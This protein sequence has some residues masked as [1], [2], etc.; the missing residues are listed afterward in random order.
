MARFGTN[1]LTLFDPFA[2]VEVYRVGDFD[3][4][5]ITTESGQVIPLPDAG[6]PSEIGADFSIYQAQSEVVGYR[7]T[8]GRFYDLD[9]SPL[10]R[11]DLDARGGQQIAKERTLTEGVFRDR[12]ADVVVLPRAEVALRVGAGTRLSA[13]FNAHARPADPALTSGTL[14]EYTFF[15]A[16]QGDLPNGALRPERVSEVGLS[17]DQALAVGRWAG[18]IGATGYVRRYRDLVRAVA[19]ND[20]FPS[21]YRSVGNA[22]AATVPGLD[23][24]LDGTAGR[25]SVFARGGVAWETFEVAEGGVFGEPTLAD[26]SRLAADAA[27]ALTLDTRATDGPSVG[28][29]H[30]LGGL[31][32][33]AVWRVASGEPYTRTSRAVPVTT[34]DRFL[35]Y[36]GETGAEAS[37]TRT[38]LDLRLARA[39]GLGAAG[40]LEAALWVENLLGTVQVL[41]AYPFTGQPDDDGYLASDPDNV[42]ALPS[43]TERDAF[44]AQYASLVRNPAGVGR[45]RQVRLGLRMSF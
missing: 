31:H 14:A 10:T 44:R 41:S 28:G 6:I 42:A 19:L 13:F 37:P 16:G 20:A 18:R 34:G 11:S 36:V 29:V 32:L 40:T 12:E 38:R 45:P 1:A 3:G 24:R 22:G 39:F 15:I 27:V 35:T 30:P 9:G 25:L 43:E 2:L 26:L 21:G 4:G 8:D 33:G 17:L 5:A 7:D 23:L